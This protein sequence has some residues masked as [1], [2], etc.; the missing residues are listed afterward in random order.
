MFL[1][2][3]SCATVIKVQSARPSPRG[4]RKGRSV[5]TRLETSGPAVALRLEADRT[6]LRADGEDATV[7]NVIAV[8]AKG[9]EVPDAC[10][11]AYFSV[12]GAG[13]ILGVGN[14]D[15]LS[16]EP[17]VCPPDAWTRKLFNGRCQLVLRAAAQPGA[18]TVRAWLTP[19]RT[20]AVE[21]SCIPAVSR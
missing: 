10:A 8:D 19:E 1:K 18:L 21:L 11:Q 4:V 3:I 5:V 6:T 14:G 16:H 20:A 7:V 9:R 17:D 2:R 15:P 12:A 13:R